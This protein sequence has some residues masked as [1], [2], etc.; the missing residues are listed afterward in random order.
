M[1]RR[2]V[3]IATAAVLL[4]GLLLVIAA[5]W[6]AL[7]GIARWAVTRQIEAQT[8]RRLTMAAFDLDVPRRHI[9][10]A[11]LHL[12]DRE[13]GPPLLEFDTLDI[14]FRL[15]DL[16]RGRVH[17]RDVTLTA[18][19]LRIVRTARG[20]LNIADLLERPAEPGP[21]AP[22]TLDRLTVSGGTILFEDR[23]LTP[24]R[25]WRAEGLTVEATSLSTMSP[26]P[27][28]AVRLATTVAGAPRSTGRSWRSGCGS[29]RS[30]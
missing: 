8:G 19:R 15:R 7:P 13:P 27:V 4:V 18:P 20:V 12:A 2:R 29:R 3:W 17:L 30:S 14:R 10:V 6:L 5:L 22:F 26:E 1:T 24:P 23:A 28:G 16:L 25:A 9:H 21:L 11:G